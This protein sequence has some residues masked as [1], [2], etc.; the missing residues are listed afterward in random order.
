MHIVNLKFW[1]TKVQINYIYDINDVELLQKQHNNFFLVQLLIRGLYLDLL[2][3]T[4]I[5]SSWIYFIY[6]YK[7]ISK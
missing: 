5:K 4:H 1:I 7:L 2:L 6:C 3:L